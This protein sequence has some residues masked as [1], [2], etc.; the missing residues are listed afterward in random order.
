VSPSA[1]KLVPQ[2]SKCADKKNPSSAV[3]NLKRNVDGSEIKS[4]LASKMKDKLLLDSSDSIYNTFV[5]PM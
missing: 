1:S 3:V 2:V 4:F 5:T